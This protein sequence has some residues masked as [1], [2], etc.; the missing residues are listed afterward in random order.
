MP[1]SQIANDHRSNPSSYQE[2]ENIRDLNLNKKIIFGV[3]SFLFIITSFITAI[4]LL[5]K[6]QDIRQQATDNVYL[7]NQENLNRPTTQGNCAGKGAWVNN[8]CYLDWE[9]L[10]GGTH[11][12]VPGEYNDL[13]FSSLV[14]VEQANL[15]KQTVLGNSDTTVDITS[16]S[17]NPTT[18]VLPTITGIS[19]GNCVAPFMA[20]EGKCVPDQTSPLWGSEWTENHSCGAMVALYIAQQQNPNINPVAF[21]ETYYGEY[22]FENGEYFNQDTNILKNESVLNQ[23]GYTFEPTNNNLIWRGEELLEN[24]EVLF[25]G[26]NFGANGGV[27]HYIAITDITPIQFNPDGSPSQTKIEVVDSYFGIDECVLK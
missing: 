17:P 24:G 2:E 8:V 21:L 25:V 12:V 15:I 22:Y 1:D 11:M 6:N 4:L 26:T 14:P 19:S 13:G 18:Y 7:G 16:V 27:A 23:L 9:V 5:N 10:P 20:V 3:F